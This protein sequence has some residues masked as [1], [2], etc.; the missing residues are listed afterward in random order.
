MIE[1]LKIRSAELKDVDIIKEIYNEA[2]V[3]TN[4]TF[5]T[6]EKTV[7]EMKRW[8]NNHDSKNP[9]L[10]AEKE[11]KTI[12]WASLSKYDNKKAYSDTAELSLYV[13]KD[14]Q[15]KG[16]GKKLMD[17]ILNRGKKAGLHAVIARI[18]EGNDISIHLH[19][20]F[21]F[22]KIGT[23][24]QVGKKFGKVLDVHIFEKIFS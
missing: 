4:A 7:E 15:G 11:G 24:R 22:E 13:L 9:V 16:I 8:F 20:N 17:E 12:A 6:D 1:V 2:V 10:I 14:F 18:T 21:G 5:D 19:E 3:N 23:L